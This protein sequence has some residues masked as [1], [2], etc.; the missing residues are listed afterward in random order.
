MAAYALTVFLSSFLLFQVQPL[1]GKYILPW[2]GGS[3]AV[4]TTCMLFFQTALLAGYAYAYLLARLEEKRQGYIHAFLLIIAFLFLPIAPSAEFW[5][6]LPEEAPSIKILILLAANIGVPYLLLSATAPLVQHWFMR[7]FPGRSPYRLYALSNFGS[8]LAL[9]SYPFLFEP[10]LTLKR[11]IA[12]WGW[13]F[14]CFAVCCIWCA[15]RLIRSPKTAGYTSDTMNTTATSGLAMGRVIIWLLLSACGSA[16]LLA[17]TNQLCQEVAVV[18]FLWVAPLALYLLSFIIYFN[19]ERANDRLLWGL[20]LI[21]AL[22]PACRV[23]YLGVYANLP[24]QIVVYLAVLFAGCMVCH[25]ELARTRPDPSKLTAYYLIIATGGAIGGVFVA[26][27]APYLFRGFW[28]FPITLVLSCMVILAAWFRD[29]AFTGA[30]RWVPLMLIAGQVVLILYAGKYLRSYSSLAI[31]STRNFYGV[32]RVIR[33]TDGNGERLSLMHG[34]VVHG[35]QFTSPDKRHLPT[36]YYGPDSAAGLALRLH[37]RRSADDPRQQTLKVGVVG[38]GTGTLAAY[39][40]A[41]DLFRFYEINPAVIRLSDR[42][43]S[44]RRDSRAAVEIAPGDARIVMENEL[45]RNNPQDFDLLIIDAFS[46]D[47]IPVHL[48]TRECFSIYRQHLKP[49]GLLLVHITNRFLHL[50]PVVR[51][52]AES[53]GIRAELVS[54]TAEPENGIGKSDWMILSNNQRFFENEEIEES[55]EPAEAGLSP[56]LWT[57]DFASL[58]KILKR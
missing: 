31:E 3:P 34:G 15:I 47:A 32:L 10:N 42:F 9:V 8:L 52:L 39:G 38:L 56:L 28:E 1:I 45:K 2:F 51:A 36:T 35:T 40:K 54:S 24:V 48:L 13:G 43:F 26:L 50:E 49:D 27:A 58:W 46:S 57:D 30:P 37:P 6:P 7:S 20:L 33:E 53:S 55:L 17:T 4:W 21:G 18:P 29:G 22:V 5:R 44:F 14:A 16:L 23:F 11:Q 12:G 25:G 41:G 19:S